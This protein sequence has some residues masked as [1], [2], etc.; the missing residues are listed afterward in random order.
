MSLFEYRATVWVDARLEIAPAIHD[1]DTIKLM[2]DQ[3]MND[4]TEQW[5]RLEGVSAPE[6]NQNGGILTRQFVREWLGARVLPGGSRYRAARWPLRVLT[7]PTSTTEPSERT[8]LARYLGVVYDL[9]SGDCLNA[10]VQQ[11][12]GE[13]PDWPRGKQI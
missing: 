9:A 1:G 13:H 3:G 12:L 5:I 10:Q 11:F 7:T 2:I 4:R 6:I 8:T